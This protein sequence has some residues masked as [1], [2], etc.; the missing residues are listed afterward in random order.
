MIK[1]AFFEILVDK[2]GPFL[3]HNQFSVVVINSIS[4]KLPSSNGPILALNVS[5]EALNCAIHT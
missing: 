2:I 1:S 4:S 3:S 5:K